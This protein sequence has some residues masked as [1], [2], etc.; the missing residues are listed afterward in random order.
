MI[1]NIIDNKNN[2]LNVKIKNFTYKINNQIKDI[3]NRL[4]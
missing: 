3:N 1:I 2:K 4:N